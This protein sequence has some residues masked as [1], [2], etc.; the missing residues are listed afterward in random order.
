M[1]D[2]A[3]TTLNIQLLALPFYLQNNKSYKQH[4]LNS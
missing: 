1:K 4:V 2:A 3:A